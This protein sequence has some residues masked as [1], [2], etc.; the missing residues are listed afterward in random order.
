MCPSK[1]ENTICAYVHAI[2]E[3]SRTKYAKISRYL[4]FILCVFLARGPLI[5]FPNPKTKYA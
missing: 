4:S 3:A 5:F 1:K 2:V